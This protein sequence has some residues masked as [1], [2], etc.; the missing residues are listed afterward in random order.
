M[1]YA[2]RLLVGPSGLGGLQTERRINLAHR[3]N[4]TLAVNDW[5]TAR[6]RTTRSVNLQCIGANRRNDAVADPLTSA[7]MLTRFN[8]PAGSWAPFR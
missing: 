4:F 6:T 1:S 2:V 5:R 8:P 7:E 3:H